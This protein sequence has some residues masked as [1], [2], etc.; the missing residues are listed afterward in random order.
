[1]K[2]RKSLSHFERALEAETEIDRNR[3]EA[4]KR[5][6]ERR[7]RKRTIERHTREGQARFILLSI[8]LTT[9]AIVVSILMFRLL[10]VLLE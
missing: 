2:L 7:A 3:R 5:A 4:L 1:M 8:T 6:A 9:T 10:Y